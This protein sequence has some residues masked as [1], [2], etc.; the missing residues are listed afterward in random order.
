MLHLRVRINQTHIIMNTKLIA[1]SICATALTATAFAGPTPLPTP[2]PPP[3]ELGFEAARRPMTNP[4][5]FDLAVPRTGVHAIYMHQRMPSQISSTLGKLDLDGSFD[6]Y[7]LQFEYAFTDR[8]S[9]VATK[10][11]YID[12]NPDGALFSKESGFADVAAGLKYAFILDPVQQLAVSGTL[13][14]EFA[15]GDDEVFQGN[16]NG[17]INLNFAALKLL[18]Q[19]Q[20]AGAAGVYLPF[21][22]DEE[23]TT[24]FASAHV[25]YNFT[26]KIYGLAE[27][28]WFTVLSRG[29]GYVNFK[30]QAGGAAPAV[31]EFE[32]G[33]LINLGALNSNANRD[34]V[35]AAIGLRYKL[36]D[37]ADLGVAYELPLTDDEDNLMKDRITVDLVFT[38]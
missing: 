3:V 31:T 29:E 4:T 5:L 18:N 2:T 19:W 21:D 12:F 16:G 10:D 34:I 24:A 1:T 35:T 7:A 20:F 17:G 22:N 8:L 32:G 37:M 30:K 26:D 27:V 23:A 25:G 14:V 9:L 36:C 33:D 28:N 13:G 38:F 6:V 15:I 11:G